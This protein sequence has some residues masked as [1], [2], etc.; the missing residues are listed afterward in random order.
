MSSNVL[1]DSFHPSTSPQLRR[2]VPGLA[3]LTCVSLLT[4][5]TRSTL[6]QQL[7]D[8]MNESSSF[9]ESDLKPFRARLNELRE[10]VQHDRTSGLH[11]EAMTM[12][13]ERKLNACGELRESCSCFCLAVVMRR[14]GAKHSALD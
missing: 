14:D 3:Q 12:L 1:P 13:L 4:P 8:H 10:I 6:L 5:T 9:T 2:R 11:P 7:L